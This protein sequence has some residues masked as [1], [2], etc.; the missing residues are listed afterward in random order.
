MTDDRPTFDTET[1]ETSIEQLGD[2]RGPMAGAAI[3]ALS[4]AVETLADLLKGR[5]EQIHE[6]GELVAYM[7]ECREETRQ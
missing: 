1:P 5:D 2:L 7:A 6:M 4:R 3:L